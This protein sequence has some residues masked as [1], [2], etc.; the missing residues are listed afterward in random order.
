MKAQT[1]KIYVERERMGYVRCYASETNCDKATRSI[2]P[3]DAD[4][5][6]EA[7]RKISMVRNL[8][9]MNE[10]VDKLFKDSKNNG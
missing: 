7:A 6:L 8:E 2:L 1:M 3:L 9:T 5:I 10:A 4:D